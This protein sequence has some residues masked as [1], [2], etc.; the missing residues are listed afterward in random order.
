VSLIV[1]VNEALGEDGGQQDYEAP[2]GFG[3]YEE[4]LLGGEAKPE[5]VR[6]T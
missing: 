3:G 1:G 5:V 2:P 4:P 6:E